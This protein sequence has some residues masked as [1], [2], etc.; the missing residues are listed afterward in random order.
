[1]DP[2]YR[3]RAGIGD[4][5]RPSC[6]LMDTP[7]RARVRASTMLSHSPGVALQPQL[8]SRHHRYRTAT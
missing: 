3:T 2:Y 8:P 6:G 7:D 5:T 4:L 1:M